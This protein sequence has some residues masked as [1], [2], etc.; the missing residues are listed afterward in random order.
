[1][2]YFILTVISAVI[3][4]VY[5]VVATRIGG[6][7]PSLSDSYYLFEERSK[8]RGMV[9]YVTLLLVVF[10]CIFPMCEVAGGL[11]VLA[12]FALLLV[13]AAPKFKDRKTLERVLH[14]GGSATASIVAVSIL[15]KTGQ[16]LV[17]PWFA[18]LFLAIAIAS[19]TLKRS[20]LFWAEMVA[21][22][23]FFAGLYIH[24]YPQ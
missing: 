9:F 11:G 20:W 1:M 22:Y 24:F 23:A 17:V 5:A 18:L 21:F 4:T 15:A 16:L 3:F 2:V 6:V 19:K 10:T 7:L 14:Y 8:G 13:G 12:G